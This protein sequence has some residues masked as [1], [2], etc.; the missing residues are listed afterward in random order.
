M[1]RET[2]A[3]KAVNWK[4]LI[5]NWTI[6]HTPGPTSVKEFTQGKR[7]D[8]KTVARSWVHSRA[9]LV[10]IVPRVNGVALSKKS[11][12]LWVNSGFTVNEQDDT[13]KFNHNLALIPEALP[14]T[15]GK[16]FYAFQPWTGPI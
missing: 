3:Q 8:T 7:A 9:Y 1:K 4:A 12:R 16:L 10:K 15:L 13:L 5:V 11:A 14:H 6:S 2:E